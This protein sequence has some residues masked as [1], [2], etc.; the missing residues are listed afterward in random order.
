M[1]KGTA[2]FVFVLFVGVI[3]VAGYFVYKK[4]K[5]KNKK[6]EMGAAI[7]I[8]PQNPVPYDSETSSQPETPSQPDTTAVPELRILGGVKKMTSLEEA[9]NN[10]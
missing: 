6:K 7:P 4:M 9:L 10:L 3:A 8:D 2:I 1:S 5:G